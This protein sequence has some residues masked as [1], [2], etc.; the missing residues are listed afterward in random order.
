MLKD[1]LEE[2]VFIYINNIFT[3]SI[4]PFHQFPFIKAAALIIFES[5]FLFPQLLLQNSD[6][7]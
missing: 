2:L 1:E 5:D 4:P 3:T 6:Q 7:S